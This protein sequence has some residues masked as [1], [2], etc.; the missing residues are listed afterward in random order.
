MQVRLVKWIAGPVGAYIGNSDRVVSVAADVELQSGMIITDGEL[1]KFLFN[2]I[3]MINF[4]LER[5]ARMYILVVL[6]LL[7]LLMGKFF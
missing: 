5:L 3:K 6:T 1:S 7:S 4:I 2:K